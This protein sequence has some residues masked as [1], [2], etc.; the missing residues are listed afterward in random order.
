MEAAAAKQAR[1]ARGSAPDRLSALSDELLCHVLSFLPSRQAVQTTVLSKSSSDFRGGHWWRKLQDFT[2]NLLM[3]NN[4][5]CLDAFRLD[6]FWATEFPDL[7]RD[8]ERWVRRGIKC[9]PPVF[10]IRVYRD[11]FRSPALAPAFISSKAWS[12][13][14]SLDPCFS[15]RLSSGCPVLEDLLL[16]NCANNFAVVQSDTLRNLVVRACTSRVADTLVVRAPC[17]ASMF[18]DSSCY[19]NG[20]SL[21]AGNSLVKASISVMPEQ[22]SPRTEAILLGSL[23]SVTSLELQFFQAMAFLDN[24]LDK[25]PMFDNLRTLS[26]SYC[27]F[28]ER[29]AD[30]LKALGRFLHKSPNLEELIL[31]DF[32]Y[33]EGTARDPRM[34]Q[35]K[36]VHPS[37][38]TEI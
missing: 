11:I 7:C 3:L 9:Q 29:D 10:Q 14:V 13:W 34:G 20:L 19:N 17:L 38:F 2:N 24:E 31:Q 36:T 5:R 6:L 30:K 12:L 8:T 16:H 37:F 4:A 21:E 28:S 15:E 32:W 25:F 18:L 27:F 33:S 1:T 26:L 35:L 23:F 22:L